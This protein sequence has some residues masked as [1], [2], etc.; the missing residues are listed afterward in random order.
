MRNVGAHELDG[1][2][3][4]IAL[5]PGVKATEGEFEDRVSL[6]RA[7]FDTLLPW[8]RSTAE[9]PDSASQKVSM[10]L[11]ERAA[12]LPGLSP[13]QLDQLAQLRGDLAYTAALG[14]VQLAAGLVESARRRLQ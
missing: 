1:A 2:Y 14:E 11:A 3:A 10:D 4:P 9:K 12:H 13:A 7:L 8:A 6:D 5:P